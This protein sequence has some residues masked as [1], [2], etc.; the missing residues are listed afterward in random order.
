M[1]QPNNS[2]EDDRL[3]RSS[4]GSSRGEIL[5]LLVETLECDQPKVQRPV[6]LLADSLGRCIPET[7]S[8]IQP[9]VKQDYPF[10][11]MAEDVAAGK[12]DLHHRMV[13]IWSGAAQVEAELDVLLGDLKALI[14]IIR[15][16]NKHIQVF[17]SSI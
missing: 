3:S 2:L 7:D 1:K 11:R 10:G 8:I 16:K 15:V 17:V 5:D 4:N 13:I 12:V 14:N 9:V 6:L